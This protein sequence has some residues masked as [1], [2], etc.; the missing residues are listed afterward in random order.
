MQDALAKLVTDGTL[1]QAQADAVVNALQAARPSMGEGRGGHAGGRGGPGGRMA[2]L[3]VAADA[4]GVTAEELRTALRSGTS[5]A[6]LATSK[7]D[8]VQKVIDAL[9]AEA[10]AKL[11]QAVTDGRLTQAEADTR[12]T[13]LTARITDLVNGTLPV[14]GPAGGGRGGHGPMHDG[15]GDTSASTAMTTA[16]ATTA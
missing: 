8:D 2:D 9:V 11:A 3:S 7:G 1:T 12:I 6:E 16:T 14:G 4:I 13:D 5:L 10:T 15:A